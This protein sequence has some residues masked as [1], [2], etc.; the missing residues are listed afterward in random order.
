MKLGL[1]NAAVIALCAAGGYWLFSRRPSEFAVTDGTV[2]LEPRVPY[3]LSLEASETVTD[4]PMNPTLVDRQNEIR[5]ELIKFSA[6]DVSF[7]RLPEAGGG[8]R[9]VVSF[10]MTPLFPIPLSIGAPLDNA[11]KWGPKLTLYKVE[12]LDGKRF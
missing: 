10:R 9:N 5:T 4:Y 1:E 3:R 7:A 11:T 12:R 2:T 6:Y 8:S